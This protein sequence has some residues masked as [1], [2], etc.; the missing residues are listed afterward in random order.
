MRKL[1]ENILMNIFP[2]KIRKK[3]NAKLNFVGLKSTPEHFILISCILSILFG[4]GLSFFL[5][6]L[7]KMSFWPFFFLGFVVGNSLMYTWLIL[8]ADKKVALI[9]EALPDALQLMTSNLNA[10]MTPDKAILLSARSEF[11]PLKE[12]I[13][14]IGRKVALGK[15][16]GKALVEMAEHIQS[17]KLLRSVEL[18]NSGLNSGG[19]L[20]VLLE[21]TAGHLKA[22]ALIDKRIK[23]SITT[24][25]IFIFSA[26]GLVTPVLLGLSSILI[27][28]LQTNLGAIEVPPLSLATVPI[29]SVQTTITPEFLL[30]YLL[31]FLV[32]NCFLASILLGLV[33]KGRQREGVKFFIPMIILA[34]SLFFLVRYGIMLVLG[35]LFSI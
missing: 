26:A 4:I 2:Q 7:L 3:L 34:V 14:R 22:Q 18:I 1:R 25:L 19:N 24:Y 29:Q 10:G 8:V 5:S 6:S 27:N 32:V 33:G 11:G 31:T 12:E 28:V 13:D 16:I 21:T 15:S 23:A 17:K 9:E 20:S 35:G 30:F